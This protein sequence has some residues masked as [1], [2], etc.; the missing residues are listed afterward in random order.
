[1]GRPGK[2]SVRTAANLR[3]A[4]TLGKLTREE[5]ALK[6]SQDK[7]EKTKLDIEAGR[8]K[9]AE[10]VRIRAARQAEKDAIRAAALA[11]KQP[12]AMRQSQPT[13]A[14]V[15]VVEQKADKI[16]DPALPPRGYF[17]PAK[18]HQPPDEA[19]AVG[20]FIPE[21]QPD[22]KSEEQ[23]N[24]VEVLRRR[25]QATLQ[26]GV[27]AAP[28]W[29][30]C[31]GVVRQHTYDAMLSRQPRRWYEGERLCRGLTPWWGPR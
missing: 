19:P 10:R 14:M 7:L 1:M 2:T 9:E 25:L 24:R 31:G 15:N 21:K 16:L 23:P 30:D 22:P 6:R 8:L 12:K 26:P 27:S 11:A 29:L 17:D 3:A 13:R 20:Y 18:M 4:S 5:V 28:A